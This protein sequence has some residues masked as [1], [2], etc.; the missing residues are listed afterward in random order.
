MSCEEE[1]KTSEQ[2]ENNLKIINSSIY[3]FFMENI[4]KEYIDNKKKWCNIVYKFPEIIY[5]SSYTINKFK[6]NKQKTEIYYKKKIEM[7][8]KKNS[9]KLIAFKYFLHEKCIIIFTKIDR[10]D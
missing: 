9:F 10:C 8:C 6:E 4:K 7:F 2:L 5:D 3:N 1:T